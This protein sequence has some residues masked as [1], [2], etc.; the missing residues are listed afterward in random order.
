ME[1]EELWTLEV[2]RLLVSSCILSIHYTTQTQYQKTYIRYTLPQ[3][4]PAP[5]SQPTA[6]QP[7][8]LPLQLRYAPPRCHPPAA[9]RSKAAAS[10]AVSMYCERK[11]CWVKPR[12]KPAAQS[13]GQLP[14]TAS[15]FAHLSELIEYLP[16]H[17][18]C[19]PHMLRK[20]EPWRQVPS[21]HAVRPLH[22]P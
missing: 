17:G 12:A 7:H 11:I 16:L 13:D 2:W 14:S 15:Q 1:L 20:F 5:L 6:S 4:K 3:A 8:S 18:L 22:L 19:M 21:R 10:S 9:A